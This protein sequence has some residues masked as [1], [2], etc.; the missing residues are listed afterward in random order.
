VQSDRKLGVSLLA[1]ELN[2]N[3]ERMSEIVTDDLGMRKFSSKMVPRILKH[4][5][6][7]RRLHISSDF[8]TLQRCLIGPLP[9][10]KRGAFNTT[11][12]ENARTCSGKHRIHFGRR[13]HA[14]LARSSGS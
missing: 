12:K 9:M 3:R 8:Y 14:C 11:R 7:Q 5:Q 1:E 4:D 2:M 6:K 10:M 13:N